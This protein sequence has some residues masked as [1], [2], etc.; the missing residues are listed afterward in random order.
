[1]AWTNMINHIVEWTVL[2]KANIE[3]HKKENKRWD[4]MNTNTAFYLSNLEVLSTPS[5]QLSS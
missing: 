1:M 3:T 5:A 2:E 4:L